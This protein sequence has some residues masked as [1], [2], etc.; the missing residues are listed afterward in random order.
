MT[1]PTLRLAGDDERF[2]DLL[3]AIREQ[4]ELLKAAAR[5]ER[6]KVWPRQRKRCEY[7]RPDLGKMER[8]ATGK[9]GGQW[10]SQSA[11]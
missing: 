5:A 8:G 9:G 7:A 10:A 11:R 2:D 6:S 3:R 1:S 4:I